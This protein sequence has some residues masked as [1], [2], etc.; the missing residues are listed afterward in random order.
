MCFEAKKNLVP[1]FEVV[2]GQ[3]LSRN[4]VKIGELNGF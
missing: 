1:G 3:R 2:P 4:G